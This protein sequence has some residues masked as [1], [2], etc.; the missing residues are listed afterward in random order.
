M[1]LFGLLCMYDYPKRFTF[2]LFLSKLK[3]VLVFFWIL[4]LIFVAGNTKTEIQ[5]TVS[6][7]AVRIELPGE[8][9]SAFTY[10]TRDDK[11]KRMQS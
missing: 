5:G 2:S 7:D 6:K 9:K 10:I 1:T 3:T 11:R 8:G 4:I